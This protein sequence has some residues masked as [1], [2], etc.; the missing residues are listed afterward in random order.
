MSTVTV[1]ELQKTGVGSDVLSLPNSF[2]DGKVGVDASGNL[3]KVDADAFVVTTVYDGATQAGATE[4]IFNVPSTAFSSTTELSHVRF[5]GS[6]LRNDQSSSGQY[7]I[8]Y[9][10]ENEANKSGTYY[11]EN[12]ETYD[13]GSGYRRI[14]NQSDRWTL[15]SYANGFNPGARDW[16][17]LN[18]DLTINFNPQGNNT[19]GGL[20]GY[21]Q[22]YLNNSTYNYQ[23]G[24]NEVYGYSDGDSSGFDGIKFTWHN[25]SYTFQEGQ[26]FA[27][28]YP[29]V[30]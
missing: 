5:I 13:N 2:T 10:Q 3:A 24:L 4:V 14:Y 17:H 11:T 27:I 16:S 28:Y 20:N 8:I 7:L 23:H 30:S 1:N 26:I 12:I 9:P 19:G 18:F 25:T 15:L 29:K 21:V 22:N 6:G